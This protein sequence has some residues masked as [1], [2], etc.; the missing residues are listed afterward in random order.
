MTVRA[1]LYYTGSGVQALTTAEV[2]EWVDRAIYEYSQNPSVVLSVVG[3]SGNTGTIND[4]RL[5]AGT[6]LTDVTAFPLE[7]STP[8]PTTVSIS[9]EKMLRSY[10]ASG[11]IGQTVDN[12]I[13]YPVFYDSATNAL[14]A[15]PLADILDT[16]C[17][18]A[19]DKLISASES[20]TTAGTYTISTSSS[21][22]N[23]TEVSG[24]T[25]PIYSDTRADTTAYSAAGIPETLDQPTTITNYY[26]HRRDGVTSTPSRALMFI[27]AQGNLQEFSIATAA[28]LLGDWVRYTAAHDV[29]GYKI[30]YTSGTSGSGNIRGSS[31]TDTKL[32]GSGDY[33]TLFVDAN[34]YRAQEF[35]NGIATTISTYNLYINKS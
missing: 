29:S 23:Y 17:Y 15:M 30:S 25:T 32:N 27:T 35:P 3:S 14:K 28:T 21:L 19:I 8:E 31:M 20:S 6:Y 10:T 18:P 12:G 22:A 33:Q 26:L 13:S 7:S 34:D 11:S 2:T 4:T 1:P 16:F 24:T 9:Y 5:Q